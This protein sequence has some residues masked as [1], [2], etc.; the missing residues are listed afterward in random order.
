MSEWYFKPQD[1]DKRRRITA[2]VT[3]NG[4]SPRSS[5][6]PSDNS[7]STTA[8]DDVIQPSASVIA[9]ATSAVATDHSSAS[10]STDGAGCSAMSDDDTILSEFS[11]NNGI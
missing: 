4:R 3:E 2:E 9:D 6:R 5:T 1:P 7:R 11:H 10:A 8:A